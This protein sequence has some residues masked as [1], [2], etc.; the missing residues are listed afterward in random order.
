MS[1]P[2]SAVAS[3][4]AR[5]IFDSR[6]RP[7]IEVD[8]TLADGRVGRAC[9]PSGASTGRHEAVELRDGDK[10]Q[11]DGLGVSKAVANVNSEIAAAVIGLD[12]LRQSPS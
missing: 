8:V 6:G 10:S 12:S 11:F 4:Q 5:Q 1:R 2:S 7:T 9:A 3:V